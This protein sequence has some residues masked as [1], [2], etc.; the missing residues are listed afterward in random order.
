[1]IVSS[2]LI[3]HCSW[4]TLLV[5]LP[6][7]FS[8]ALILCGNSNFPHIPKVLQIKSAWDLVTRDHWSTVNSL[9][10]SSNQVEVLP[11]LRHDALSCI[12]Q[13]VGTLWYMLVLRVPKSTKETS[14]TLLHHQTQLEQ[15][16]ASWYK[17]RWCFHVVYTNF[18]TYYLNVSAAI[19]THQTRQHIFLFSVV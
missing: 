5:G 18:W 13:T 2:A 8:T 7:A 15:G 19:D 4:Y 17:A 12:H 10:C 11:A 6:F 3:D 1:M 14:P 16:N 9:S